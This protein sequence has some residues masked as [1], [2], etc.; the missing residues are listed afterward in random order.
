MPFGAFFKRLFVSHPGREAAAPE[1]WVSLMQACWDKEP[2]QRPSF[3]S[4]WKQLQEIR[5]RVAAES[6]AQAEAQRKQSAW[7]AALRKTP[8]VLTV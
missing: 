5:S 1:G 8:A 6:F 7:D 4:V 3:E 2:K